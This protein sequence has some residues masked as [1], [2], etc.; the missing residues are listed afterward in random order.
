MGHD[1]V[2]HSVLPVCLSPD[3][4]PIYQ[5]YVPYGDAL[6]TAS[7]PPTAKAKTLFVVRTQQSLIVLVRTQTQR[8]T[9]L[10][11]EK[12][13]NAMQAATSL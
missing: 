3:S 11:C 9:Q 8:K 12:Q 7:S 5:L 6:M 13:R 1:V 2:L 4:Y 10:Q